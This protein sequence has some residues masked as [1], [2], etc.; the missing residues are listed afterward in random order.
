MNE[1]VNQPWDIQQFVEAVTAELDQA[2]DLSRFK[3][4]AG[5][6]L[7]YMVQG[8]ELNLNVFPVYDGARV[9]FRTA[10]P[11]ETGASSLKLELGSATANVVELTT[12]PPAKA[13]EVDID[14]IP[15]DQQTREKLHNVGI[16]TRS[17]IDRLGDTKLKSDDGSDV[18]FAHLAELMDEVTSGAPAPEVHKVLAFQ[19]PSGED[20]LRVLGSRLDQVAPGGV[21]IDRAPV[22]ASVSEDSIELSLPPGSREGLSAHKE[23]WMR[24]Q[25]GHRL[26]VM[27]K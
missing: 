16:D 1:D 2:R 14:Q 7:T 9:S 12:K 11:N 13:G 17:D 20:R 26:R 18:D 22:Q 3:S 21:S 24:L 27:L 25:D 15:L 10:G 6:P 23:L 19:T 5:R 4:E 8:L